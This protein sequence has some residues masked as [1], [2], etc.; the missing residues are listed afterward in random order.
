MRRCALAIGATF[1]VALS[2]A[3]VGWWVGPDRRAERMR[4]PCQLLEP[5]DPSL[6]E[7]PG[8]ED[9]DAKISATIERIRSK[10]LIVQQMAE[11]R[12]TLAEA[13][14]KFRDL[15]ASD[16]Q[17]MERLRQHDPRTPDDE[18]YCE[19]V[20]RFARELLASRRDYP[21]LMAG[22]TAEREH[23]R[24][25]IGGLRLVGNANTPTGKS[26]IVGCEIP[27]AGTAVV[28]PAAVSGPLRARAK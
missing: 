20:L 22:L 12:L 23:L 16:N 3:M 4:V 26:M 9:L 17:L 24:R 25:H 27:R 8:C 11:G 10:N 5:N 7:Q 21:E 15:N 14:C 28:S 1:A 2:L 19:Q 18:I 13:A 6:T